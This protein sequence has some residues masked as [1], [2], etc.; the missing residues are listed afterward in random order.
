M[1]EIKDVSL[2]KVMQVVVHR[3][4]EQ[5]PVTYTAFDSGEGAW[6]KENGQVWVNV[7]SLIRNLEG[8]RRPHWI[9][10]AKY[11]EVDKIDAEPYLEALSKG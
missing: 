9:A 2:D 8:F 7:F 5:L 11:E 1:K 4:G 3:K 10:V 6:K